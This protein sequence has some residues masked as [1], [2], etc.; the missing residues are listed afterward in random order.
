MRNETIERALL[1]HPDERLP[2][3]WA[4]IYTWILEHIRHNESCK[5]DFE[6]LLIKFHK[7]DIDGIANFDFSTP[8]NEKIQY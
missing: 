3:E 7:K 1:N 6:N 4:Y 2:V 5:R 8:S